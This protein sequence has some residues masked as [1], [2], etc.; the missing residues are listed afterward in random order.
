M[1]VIRFFALGALLLG[2]SGTGVRADWNSTIAASNPLHWFAFDEAAGAATAIDQGSAGANGTYSGAGKMATAGLINGAAS[3]AGTNSVLVGGANLATDWTLEAIFQAD[4]VNGNASMG[5]I[6]C[7]FSA[8]DRMAVKA[9]QWDMTGQLGYTRFGVVDVTF[10]GA[11]AA[12][13]AAYTHVALVGTGAGVELFVDGA[14]QGSD[15]TVTALSRY[16]LGAGAVRTN[17]TLVDGLT[18]AI[19]ELVIY[20]RALSAGD[21]AAHAAAVPEPASTV[22]SLLALMGLL[23]C[24]RRG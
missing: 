4:T 13:P 23:G 9:E 21:I 16:V 18:G 22:L 20:N 24:R 12:T 11:G 8:A 5:L 2:L 10:G 19:D 15:A 1:R 17:G 3:F 14:S 7:D 6:G